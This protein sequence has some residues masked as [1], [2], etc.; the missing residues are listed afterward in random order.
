[1]PTPLTFNLRLAAPPEAV[2]AAWSDP[3]QLASWFGPQ[4]VKSEIMAFDLSLGGAYH[5]VM[6]GQQDYVLKGT[7]TA[8]EPP[9][10]LAFTWRWEAEEAETTQLD[11]SLR[12]A[13]KGTELVVVHSGFL[14]DESRG[15][16]EQGWRATWPRLDDLFAP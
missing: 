2:Y 14:T 3:A 16:H 9:E 8:I 11:V 13:G 5:L 15:N 1:M 4:G 10:H 12:A 7:F 6:H